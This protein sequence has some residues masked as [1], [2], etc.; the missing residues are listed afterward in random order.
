MRLK[1]AVYILKLKRLCS[2]ISTY[3]PNQHAGMQG[4]L[5]YDKVLEYLACFYTDLIITEKLSS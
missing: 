5:G 3:D 4:A 1:G 2:Y